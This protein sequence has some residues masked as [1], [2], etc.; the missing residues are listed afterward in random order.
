MRHRRLLARLLIALAMSVAPAAALP[1][2]LQTADSGTVIYLDR[3]PDE[4]REAVEQTLALIDAGGPFHYRQDG[5]IFSNR[6]GL[7][8]AEPHGYY[9]EYTVRTAGAH[10]RGARRIVTGAGGEVYYTDNHY[11]NF[12]RL[13]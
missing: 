4:E 10:D 2:G 13:R 5:A 11:A 8:P 1:H 3:L 12:W 6:E 7:L 9:H